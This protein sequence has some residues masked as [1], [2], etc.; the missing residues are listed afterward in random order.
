MDLAV[1]YR[2]TNTSPWSFSLDKQTNK[3]Q[4]TRELF[5]FIIKMQ[6]KFSEI[7]TA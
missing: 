6:T 2:D 3:E 7:I 5:L 1:W 4:L